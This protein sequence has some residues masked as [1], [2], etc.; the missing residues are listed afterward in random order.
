[1]GFRKGNILHMVKARPMDKL[2]SALSEQGEILRGFRKHPPV[3][4]LDYDGT[5]TPIVNNPAKAILP[6]LTREVIAE[7]ARHWVI[8][9]I[10]GRDLADVRRLVDIDDIYYAGS[11]GFDIT[12]PGGKCRKQEIGQRFRPALERIEQKLR[13]LLQDIPGVRIERKRFT[14]A[15]HYRQ[16][17]DSYLK[18]LEERID[19][20]LSRQSELK[21][22]LGKKVFEIRPDVAWDKGKAILYLTKAMGTDHRSIPIFIG[23][24]LTDEDAFRA[25]GK[26]G[27]T[28][29]V[30]NE[31]RPTAAQYVLKDPDEVKR[32]LKGLLVLIG[33]D[34]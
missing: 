8:A 4:F 20:L 33:E 2:P 19:R 21:K 5:L 18:M 29:A 16:V 17:A 10:S 12:G 13:E 22:S 15:V 11:H 27:I 9:I 23:D 34:D 25:I 24:D 30:G 31:T 3:I 7:L 14:I 28:I 6:P 32:F 1:M 26:R